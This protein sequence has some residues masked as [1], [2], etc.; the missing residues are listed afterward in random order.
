MALLLIVG[1][2]LVI[3]S[4]GQ[5][6]NGQSDQDFTWYDIDSTEY[7]EYDG[8]PIQQ[9]N[10]LQLRSQLVRDLSNSTS[11]RVTKGESY[12]D[13]LRRVVPALIL[14][15][16]NGLSGSKLLGDMNADADKN[17][18]STSPNDRDFPIKSLGDLGVGVDDSPDGLPSRIA[19]DEVK[20]TP[21]RINVEGL[22][23]VY[24]KVI[25][26]IQNLSGYDLDVKIRRG[27]LLEAVNGNVQNIVVKESIS[28][29]LRA[30][31][32]VKV[33][34]TAYCASQ[35]RGSPVGSKVR[36][37]PFYLNASST[38]FSSQESLWQWQNNRYASLK[39]KDYG[40]YY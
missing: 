3:V 4:T 18:R 24:F 19:N 28:V 36:I 38:V 16:D 14:L 32:S 5:C 7:D 37:T 17:Y 9:P 15:N 34:V 10:Y 35:H 13:A 12:A 22:L 39:N 8:E 33:T 1:M 25:I 26:T 21:S 23:R 20:A 6:S 29:H 27:L 30:Y 2:V 31:E 40:Y 11:V